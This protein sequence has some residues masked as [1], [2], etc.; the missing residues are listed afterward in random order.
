MPVLHL[1]EAPMELYH[2]IEQLEA[3]QVTLTEE[4]F[5]LL[6]KPWT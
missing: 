5:R 1:D 3:E 2:R 6:R 4:T